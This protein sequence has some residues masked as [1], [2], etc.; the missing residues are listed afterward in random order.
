MEMLYQYIE[1]EQQTK[2]VFNSIRND[3]LIIIKIEIS[4][5]FQVL[6]RSFIK[7]CLTSFEWR[8]GSFIGRTVLYGGH[9]PFLL[10]PCFHATQY[11][12]V[13]SVTFH[14]LTYSDAAKV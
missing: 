8:R 9:E 2:P 5:P 1:I 3:E 6:R 13:R 11:D 7:L 10:V 12:L 14:F 4:E